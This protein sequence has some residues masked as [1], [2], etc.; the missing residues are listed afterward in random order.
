MA[1]LLLIQLLLVCLKQHRRM[2]L[3]LVPLYPCGRFRR[4]PWL[5]AL[6]V[7]VVS[8]ANQQMEELCFSFSFCNFVFQINLIT[9]YKTTIRQDKMIQYQGQRGNIREGLREE[10]WSE[11]AWT[12]I[13]YQLGRER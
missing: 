2:A 1:A 6:A 13:T 12:Q 3:V 10:Q 4:I 7:V 9:L 8:G 11:P 5:P